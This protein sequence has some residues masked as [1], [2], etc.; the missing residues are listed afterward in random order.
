MTEIKPEEKIPH[1][2]VSDPTLKDRT[3]PMKNRRQ[4]RRFRKQKGG[5]LSDTGRF[6]GREPKLKNTFTTARHPGTPSTHS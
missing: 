2:T 3:K 5:N 6:S 4:I 1:E